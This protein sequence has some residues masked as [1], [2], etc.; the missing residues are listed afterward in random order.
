VADI[1]ESWLAR[2]ITGVLQC[3]FGLYCSVMATLDRYYPRTGSVIA[4]APHAPDSAAGA[5][6]TQSPYSMPFY[7]WIGIVGLSLSVIIPAV[8][9]M[10]R[11][12]RPS[13][14]KIISAYYGGDAGENDTEVTQRYLQ[15]RI[16]GDALAGWVGADLFGAFQP[17]TNQ[18]KRL[19]VHYSFE[20]KEATIERRENELLVL[21]EDPHLKRTTQAVDEVEVDRLRKLEVERKAELWRAQ[22][23]RRLC[24][25]ERREAL[26]QLEELKLQPALFCP[27]QIE[28]FRL[29]KELL[30]FLRSLGNRPTGR[31]RD[32]FPDTKAGYD[33]Y[34]TDR[35]N[36]VGL[37]EDQLTHGYALEFAP[38]VKTM[39]HKFG[40]QNLHDE[41]LHQYADGVATEV[42]IVDVQKALIELGHQ[43][44]FIHLIESEVKK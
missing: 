11:K 16:L 29:A 43:M 28:A 40:R 23:S 15:P 24:D 5:V 1:K 37:W 22:E 39:M 19:K 26:K 34:V 42:N 6:V 21:P 4:N 18:R 32:E 13:K 10:F 8:V 12:L 41:R 7:L 33:Q 14:L 9:R 30:L 44:D 25:E 17:V 20:G 31:S 2:H 3:V 38:K 27:L 35:L 36:S